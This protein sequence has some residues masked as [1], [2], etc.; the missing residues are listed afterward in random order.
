MLT[1]VLLLT[2]CCCSLTQS[3]LTLCDPMDCSTPGLAVPHHLPKFAPVYVHASVIPSSHLILWCH[4]LL[5]HWFSYFPVGEYSHC[6]LTCCCSVTKSCLTVPSPWTVTCQILL[7]MGFLR[8]ECRSRLPFLS[9]GDL[10]NPGIKPTSPA[11][12]A[13]SLPL[14]HQGSP[15]PDLGYYK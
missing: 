8:K 15:F 5:H 2:I 9:P 3:C 1:G 14:S 11:L 10:P 13:D 6:F 7:S 4:L 12:Q